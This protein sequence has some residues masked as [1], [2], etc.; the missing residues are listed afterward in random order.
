[1]VFHD[2]HI[3]CTDAAGLRN[4]PQLDT[5]V[6]WVSRKGRCGSDVSLGGSRGTKT[7][8]WCTLLRRRRRLTVMD[9]GKT[10]D[11]HTHTLSQL[12]RLGSKRAGF[13]VN[14]C[15]ASVSLP[16]LV[17]AVEPGVPATDRIE[18]EY[19]IL[20]CN[21]LSGRGSRGIS[22]YKFRKWL[23]GI[24]KA[25]LCPVCRSRDKAA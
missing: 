1:M 21:L 7:A 5:L 2:P 3:S 23:T 4:H 25:S 11:G 10:F 18:S 12:Y 24:V 14:A 17:N 16:I 20:S 15:S 19:Y 6:R 22:R 8:S 9:D 13:V